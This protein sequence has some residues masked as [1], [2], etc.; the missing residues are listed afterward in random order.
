IEPAKNVD[1]RSLAGA[2]RAH[3]GDPLARVHI[4]THMV[5]SAHFTKALFELLDL[6]QW[7]HHSPRKISAGRTRPSRRKGNAPA[8]AT[9]IVNAMVMGNTSRRGEM[10]TPKIRSP[11][12]RASTTPSRKPSRPPTAPSVP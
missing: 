8:R 12:H 2:G 6:D 9:P 3:D 7:R 1:E 10:A 4:E 11:I 5:E